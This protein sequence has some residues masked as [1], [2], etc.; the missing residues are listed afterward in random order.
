[1]MRGLIAVGVLADQAGKVSLLSS[2]EFLLG[3]EQLV[4]LCNEFLAS[5][6]QFHQPRNILR[7]EKRVLPR[8]A[9]GKSERHFIRREGRNKSA[10][11]FRAEESG[12]CIKE[13]FKI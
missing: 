3:G 6:H 5:T 12:L 7:D 4:K 1:M 13:I 9:F 11:L 2:G 8:I 10:V